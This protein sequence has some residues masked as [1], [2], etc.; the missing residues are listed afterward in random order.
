[1]VTTATNVISSLIG[2]YFCIRLDHIH[3]CYYFYFTR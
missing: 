3:L 1:M 2:V